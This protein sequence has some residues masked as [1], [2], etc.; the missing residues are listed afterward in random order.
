MTL[1]ELHY[2]MWNSTAAESRNDR[3]HGL[4][5]L[6]AVPNV[7]VTPSASCTWPSE[8]IFSETPLPQAFSPGV[9]GWVGGGAVVVC[10]SV[11]LSCGF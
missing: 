5:T 9:G 7:C 3:T 6:F 11:C 1:S 8:F 10:L 4:V 2:I